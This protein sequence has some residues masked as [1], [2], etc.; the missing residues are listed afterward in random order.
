MKISRNGKL[1]ARLDWNLTNLE[2]VITIF[3]G[4]IYITLYI[5]KYYAAEFMVEKFLGSGISYG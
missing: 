4:Y 2:W 3:L 5:F 1:V